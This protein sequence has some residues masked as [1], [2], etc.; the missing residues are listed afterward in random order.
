MS[1]RT[2]L[3]T[4]AVLG[5]LALAGCAPAASDAASISVE[6]TDTSCVLS[7]NQAPAGTV[8]FAIHNGG[9]KATEFEVFT[10]VDGSVV[11]EAEDLGPGLTRELTVQLPE[12]SYVVACVPG[13]TG[14]GIRADFSVTPSGATVTLA[15]IEGDDDGDE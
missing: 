3:P 5:A 8:T 7:D 15:P 9:A 6:A 4:L 2:L 1:H 13:M 10:A 14:D 11:S 12:G